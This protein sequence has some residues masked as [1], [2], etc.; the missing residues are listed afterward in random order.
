VGELDVIVGNEQTV[1][2]RVGGIDTLRALAFEGRPLTR[3]LAAQREAKL[4]GHFTAQRLLHFSL[5]V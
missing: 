1:V 4:F 2:G 3:A 5:N